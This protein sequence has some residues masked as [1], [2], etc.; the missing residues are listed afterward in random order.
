M[1]LNFRYKKTGNAGF[2]YT[3]IELSSQ[4]FDT[5]VQTSLMTG[6]LI[7][8]DQAFGCH[9]VKNGLCNSESFSSRFVIASF[10]SSDNFFHVGTQ[11]RATAS[12]VLTT[13]F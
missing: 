2:F 4:C 13:L 8:V 5:S 12:V 1:L 10:D 7:L 11:H 9:T 6:S 3:G